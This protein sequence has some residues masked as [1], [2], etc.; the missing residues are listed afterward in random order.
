[1]SD[2]FQARWFV[3]RDRKGCEVIPCV[4]RDHCE[5]VMAMLSSPQV[6]TGLYAI[7]VHTHNGRDWK[8]QTRCWGDS[9]SSYGRWNWT[10][11]A[12]HQI[13]PMEVRDYLARERLGVLDD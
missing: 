4:D 8:E 6:A 9:R 7:L 11:Y 13:A 10:Q 3:V 5:A 12:M 1:M 2:K